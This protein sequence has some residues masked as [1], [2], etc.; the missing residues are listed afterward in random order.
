VTAEK[1]RQYGQVIPQIYRDLDAA[2]GRILE[3]AENDYTVIV[4]SDHGM[5]P[6]T[7]P[8]G[9]LYR[10]KL[11]SL[12]EELG[13][14]TDQEHALIGLDFYLFLGDQDP[15][16]SQ[17]NEILELVNGIEVADTNDQVFEARLSGE[18]YVRIQ[19]KTAN[20]ALENALVRLPNGRT[21][22]YAELV[23]TNERTS[24]THEV[25]GIFIAAGKG[26]KAGHKLERVHLTDVTPTILT[27]LGMP[28][29]RDMDGIVLTEM[30]EERFLDAHPITYVN[31]YETQDDEPSEDEVDELSAEEKDQLEER[32]R[33]LGYLE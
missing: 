5:G 8:S 33:S 4:L 26:I 13:Y 28:V 16:K 23:S 14:S 15:E 25:E 11:A 24:G 17:V 29:A 1:A 10:P 32:L 18:K 12:L 30:I 20:P 9:Y 27:L 2:V 3:A 7:H 31:S 6:A 21:Y 19:V 22:R